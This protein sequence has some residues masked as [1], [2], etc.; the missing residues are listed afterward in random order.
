MRAATY[1]RHGRW[2]F[3][4]TTA[5][6]ICLLLTPMLVAQDIRSRVE[7][8][9]ATPQ[10]GRGAVVEQLVQLGSPA[11]PALAEKLGTYRFPMVILDALGRIGDRS[12]AAP[13]LL[14][15]S[16]VSSDPERQEERLMAIAVLRELGD[17]RAETTLYLLVTDEKASLTTRL[18]AASAL[19]KWGS[20]A[21]RQEASA[22]I[23]DTARNWHPEITS[24][25]DILDDALASVGTDESRAVLVERLGMAPLVSEQGRIIRLL[26]RDQ[27]PATAPALLAFAERNDR[28]AYIRLQAAKALVSSGLEFPRDRLVAAVQQIR[29]V[30]SPDLRPEADQV[31]HRLGN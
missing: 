15:L 7:Q 31:L 4:G 22:L 1:Q 24:R 10:P 18:A 23:M 19:S 25:A 20:P 3:A 11:V 28:E 8:I 2:W 9:L 14:F 12:A 17:T 16:R 29:N 21:I 27:A 26:A 30:L 6:A 13:V 5:L